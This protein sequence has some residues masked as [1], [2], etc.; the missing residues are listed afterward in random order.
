MN[1]LTLAGASDL[2]DA[3]LRSARRLAL[4]PLAVVVLD[5]GGHD[6]AL[7]REDGCPFLRTR[8]ARG[9]A[10]GALGMGLDSS[11]LGARAERNPRFFAALAALTEGQ[12]IPN[13]GGLLLHAADGAMLGAIGISGDTAE[14]DE[15]AAREAL[16]ELGWPPGGT[17]PDPGA[18][19]R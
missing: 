9:K 4:R 3:A 13:P 18:P 19:A 17:A 8:I 2:V 6:V 7:K 14:R 15:A 1:G 11:T 5:A 10:W 16:R 12:V